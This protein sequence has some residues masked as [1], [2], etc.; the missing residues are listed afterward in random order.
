[1]SSPEEAQALKAKQLAS[2]AEMNGGGGGGGGGQLALMGGSGSHYGPGSGG[3]GGGGQPQML[4]ASATYGHQ[5]GSDEV[6]ET[7]NVP[8]ALVGSL[9]GRGGE[10]IQ[11]IQRNS[12]C[13]VQ[14][15]RAEDQPPSAM[16]R[17][18]SLR[19]NPEAVQ[20]A[21]Q[22]I[23][24]VLSEKQQQNNQQQMS[25]SSMYGP[26]GGGGGGGGN[27]LSIKVPNMQVGLII[28][29]QGTTIK[30]IQERTGAN[31]NIPPAADVDDPVNRTITITAP[32]MQQVF[33]F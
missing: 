21:K 8:N 22:E 17:P 26:G 25:Q 24:R 16:E 18:V 6:H 19:G 2:L 7:I 31:L 27:S 15:G 3:G 9:I 28:G 29:K 12:G 11:S 13:H 23:D 14:I 33:G 20:R 5:G 32:S 30:S 4:G 10:T 1:M